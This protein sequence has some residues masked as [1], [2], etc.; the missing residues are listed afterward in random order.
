[1]KS[2][3]PGLGA[4][5]ADGFTLI[6]LSV[7]LIIVA[8]LLGTVLRAEKVVDESR[9]QR[10]ALDQA[11]IASAVGGYVRLYH[12]F[13]GDDPQAKQRWPEAMDGNGDGS[14]QF[15][16][17]EERQAWTHLRLA[18]LLSPT[19]IPQGRSLQDLGT[20]VRLVQHAAG[21]P[22]MALCMANIPPLQAAG[23]DLRFD[24]GEGRH[25]RIRHLGKDDAD[26]LLQPWPVEGAGVTVCTAL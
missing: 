13:P 22:G 24:D 6:E 5:G 21:L 23:F 8:L 3:Q 16:T 7:V 15:A 9:I 4:D 25:G 17:G 14:I 26:P 10:M 2:M 1:M 11:A 18:R 19:S 12:F 20:D